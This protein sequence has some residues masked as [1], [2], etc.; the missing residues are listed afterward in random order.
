MRVRIRPTWFTRLLVLAPH[1]AAV[2]VTL[3]LLPLPLLLRVGL[4]AVIV[5][6]LVYYYRLHVLQNSPRSV[7][8][9]EQDA[10]QNWLATISAQDGGNR[11]EQLNLRA[12]SFVSPLLL[13]LNFRGL[14]NAHYT[15]LITPGGLPKRDLRRLR[16]RLKTLKK[17]SLL[18]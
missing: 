10:A 5:F 3:V 18:S 17:T 13:V 1:L 9:I 16:V 8:Q 2:I 7:L 15:A 6:S 14:D 11:V 4:L 12:A